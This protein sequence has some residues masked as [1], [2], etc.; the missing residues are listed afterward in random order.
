MEKK[1]LIFDAD[2]TLW[3]SENDVFLAFNHTLKTKVGFEVNETEFKKLAGLSIG[4]MFE[5]TLPDDKKDLANECKNFYRSY[6]LDE[7]HCMDT[8]ELFDKVREVLEKFK[9]EGFY[10]TMASGKPKRGLD[11]MVKHFELEEMFDMVLGT[12]ES[13]FKSKP[14]PGIINYIMEE[15]NVSKEDTVMIGDSKADVLAGKNAGIDTIAATYGFDKRE[16]LENANPTYLI[17]DFEKLVD[18]I[19]I[20]K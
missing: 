14:D 17:D 11:K 7:G 15:L 9:E 1:L 10:I 13:N 2:G 8:T 6:Y 20:K 18:I 16:D 5:K 19:Q 12:G 4:T 3:D